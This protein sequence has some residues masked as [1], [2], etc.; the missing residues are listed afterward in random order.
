[1]TERIAKIGVE[2]LNTCENCGKWTTGYVYGFSSLRHFSVSEPFET[3]RFFCCDK[4]AE[5]GT[6]RIVI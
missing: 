5:A 4:C 3:K 2:R 6:G 1:M